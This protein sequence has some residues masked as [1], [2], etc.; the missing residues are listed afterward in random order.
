MLISHTLAPAHKLT[1]KQY[2]KCVRQAVGKSVVN[3]LDSA[4]WPRKWRRGPKTKR[5]V[6]DTA[7]VGKTRKMPKQKAKKV[8]D[9]PMNCI[10][11]SYVSIIG[12][13]IRGR[14]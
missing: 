2:C 1:N 8:E 12:I 3:R 14:V 10:C 9:L 6:N 5:Y 7:A 4:T 13:T 11:C